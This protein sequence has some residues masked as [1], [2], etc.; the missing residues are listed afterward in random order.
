MGVSIS[1]IQLIQ[2]RN[3]FVSFVKK[4]EVLISSFRAEAG[5]L[6]VPRF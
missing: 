2:S 1:D 6:V 5:P 4:E 3:V